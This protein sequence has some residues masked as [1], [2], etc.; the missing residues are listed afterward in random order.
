MSAWTATRSDL[1]CCRALRAPAA[2]KTLFIV[3]AAL[4]VATGLSCWQRPR[5]LFRCCW[6]RHSMRGAVPVRRV[7]WAALLAL[8]SACWLAR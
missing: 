4:E 5:C 7:A 6:E 2:L 1:P 8:G 3:T